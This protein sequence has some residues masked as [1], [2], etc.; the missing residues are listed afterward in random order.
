MS[1]KMAEKFF[2]F[3]TIN[4]NFGLKAPAYPNEACMIEQ[5]LKRKD[6]HKFFFIEALAYLF[7]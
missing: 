7:I 2:F 1:G 6:A 3:S 4:H 5:S